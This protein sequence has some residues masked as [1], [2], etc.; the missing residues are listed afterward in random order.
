MWPIIL[1]APALTVPPP[2]PDPGR[3]RDVVWPVLVAA[4]SPEGADG[5]L[6][7]TEPTPEVVRLHRVLF[8]AEREATED[9][10]LPV[11]AAPAAAG[12]AVR[13]RLAWL[14]EAPA[15]AGTP[16]PAPDLAPPAPPPLL[17][18][19][20]ADDLK[21]LRP[22]LPGGRATRV[23]LPPGAS[24]GPSEADRQMERG[25]PPPGDEGTG[26]LHLRVGG[27]G[28]AGQDTRPGFAVGLGVALAPEWQVGARLSAYPFHEYTLGSRHFGVTSLRVAVDAG[29]AVWAGERLH[30]A[31]TGGLFY[32]SLSGVGGITTTAGRPGLSLGGRLEAPLGGPLSVVV[33]AAVLASYTTTEADVSREVLRSEGPIE[34]SLALMLGWAL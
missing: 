34:A 3:L 6:W 9:I 17:P 26:R 15:E 31:A 21:T 25:E 14:L 7:A 24:F 33:E 28:T 22:A 23:P 2:P 16:R 32:A 8:V 1:L 5:L 20:R 12:E 4:A 30:L 10:I 13:L 18:P 19:E 11:D 27:E 29:Y